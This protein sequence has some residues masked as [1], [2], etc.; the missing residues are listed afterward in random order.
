M[1]ILSW[2]VSFVCVCVCVYVSLYYNTL[3][4]I[5]TENLSWTK[6]E[7]KGDIPTPREAHSALVYGDSMF[8]FGGDTGKTRVNDLFVYHFGLLLNLA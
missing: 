1:V 7:Q 8:V 2:W 4:Q 3:I 5:K 6:I